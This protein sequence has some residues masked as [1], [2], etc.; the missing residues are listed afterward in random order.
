MSTLGEALD[1]FVSIFKEEWTEALNNSAAAFQKFMR[2][3]NR[4]D[5]PQAKKSRLSK[6]ALDAIAYRLSADF[7]A[8]D[9]LRQQAGLLA[10]VHE[11]WIGARTRQRAGPKARHDVVEERHRIIAQRL[12]AG[13][14]TDAIYQE[15][16]S[17]H[18][19]LMRVKSKKDFITSKTML[20]VYRKAQP[21]TR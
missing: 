15:L 13:V 7:S 1:E 11:K 4:L 17:D 6:A 10:D 8:F 21:K 16:V 9:A 5:I 3:L 12:S 20:D 19:G 2:L 14:S 18:P